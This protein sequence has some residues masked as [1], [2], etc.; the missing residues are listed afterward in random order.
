MSEANREKEIFEQALDI[1]SLE[2]RTAFIRQ[3]CGGDAALIQRVHALLKAS[4]TAPDFLPDTPSQ[5]ARQRSDALALE[6]P[7]TVIGRYKLLEQIGEGGFGYVYMAE[8]LEPVQRRVALKILKPGMDSKQ[9]IGRFEA[10]R[11]ALALMDHPNIARIYDAGTTD[12]RARH[13]VRAGVESSESGAQGTDAPYLSSGRPY[14]VMELVKGI[15]ITKFCEQQ[16]LD[17]DARL[18]LFIEVCS[19]VQ[20]AHQKGVIHRDL[21]PS[22][23]LVTLHGDQP[24]PK[25]IDFG[26]AKATQQPLTEKTVFTQFQQFLGTPAYMSPEQATLSGLDVDTRSDIYS[27]GVLLYELLTGSPPFDSKELLSVGLDEMRRIIRQKEPMR[28]STKLSKSRATKGEKGDSH[29]AFRTPHSAFASDLDWIVMKSLEKE[30]A[31]RYETANG[32]AAD[33]KRYLNNEPVVARPPSRLYEFQ[34]TVRRHKV[35]FAAT[36]VIIL[37][38]LAGV[39]VSSWEAYRASRNANIAAHETQEANTQRRRAE[40]NERQANESRDAAQKAEQEARRQL[41]AA[42][43]TAVQSA[44]DVGDLGRAREILQNHV[45]KAGEPDLRGFVWRYFWNQARGDDLCVLRGHSNLVYSVAFSPDG[46]LLASGDWNGVVFLWDVTTRKPVAKLNPGGGAIFSVAFSPDGQ[47]L[48]IGARTNVTLWAMADPAHPKLVKQRRASR[49]RI[50]FV[51]HTTQMAIGEGTSI[52]GD[53]PGDA[54]LWD[55][56]KDKV[57]HGWNRAGG[58]IALTADGTRLFTGGGGNYICS[59]D[60]SSGKSNATAA[61]DGTL[62]TMACSHDGHSLVV[63]DGDKSF[64]ELWDGTTLE[65]IRTII[66]YQRKVSVWGAAFSPDDKLLA[67]C[68]SDQLIR[69]WDLEHQDLP[70]VVLRGHGNEVFPISFS[71]DGKLLA[72]GSKDETVRLWKVHQT[73]AASVIEGFNYSQFEVQPALS[74]GGKIFAAGWGTNA[75][76]LW[77]VDS[78]H[79]I[80]TLSNCVYALGFTQGGKKLLTMGKT[81][82]VMTYNVASQDLES[83]VILTNSSSDWRCMDLSPDGSQLAVADQDGVITL[84]DVRTGKE[85]DQ[86]RSN[87]RIYDVRFFPDGRRLVTS[88]SDNTAKVWRTDPLQK[89][90]EYDGHKDMIFSACASP[91]GKLLAVASIDNTVSIWNLRTGARLMTLRGHKRGVMCVRFTPDGNTV[92]TSSD[93]GSVRFWDLRTGREVGKWQATLGIGCLLLNADGSRLVAVEKNGRLH[94]LDAPFPADPD[95]RSTHV[96][97]EAPAS[98]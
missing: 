30:R 22:N 29:S 35:G 38:L 14:F 18:K 23:I 65:P 19:A 62:S 98:Q 39:L 15:P 50:A 66:Q 16:Q 57:L 28:P 41:Y 45:P 81:L 48:G 89:E 84:W 20:H 93:D 42:D 68:N 86:V 67:T 58:E 54:S 1:E 95:L 61:F 78:G 5:S 72:S 11:Q 80:G 71:P 9:V 2:E 3:A 27:L 52:Y 60:L 17:L 82:S 26:I 12:G 34:K 94:V 37:V 96:A 56:Q 13:S 73:A 75:V 91:D 53:P 46:R 32:L 4:E 64:A 83:V 24:V 49:A 21:K 36:A 59:W 6:G 87:G 92:I 79:V 51:P 55:F 44:L 7:G 97:T 74:P 90:G 8:Q 31:R 10:E 43:M 25:V 88:H 76:R 47:W 40:A 69:I 33:L 70:P 77:D 85:L 63:A